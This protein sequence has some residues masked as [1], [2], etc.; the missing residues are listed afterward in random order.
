MNTISECSA[1]HLL[2]GVLHIWSE[3]IV[4]DDPDVLSTVECASLRGVLTTE[5][6]M[7]GIEVIG[8]SVDCGKSKGSKTIDD[9]GTNI[10]EYFLKNPW[11]A[12]KEKMK[13]V[14]YLDVKRAKNKHNVRKQAVGKFILKKVEGMKSE[15]INS[16]QYYA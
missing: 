4:P 1:A 7:S 9:D 13:K 2:N 16:V 15:E 6:A 11:A 3:E 10:E 5:E 14:N 12:G 8:E